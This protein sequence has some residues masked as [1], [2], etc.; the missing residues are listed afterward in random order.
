[1]IYAQPQGEN[2]IGELQFQ[3]KKASDAKWYR[4]LKIV[5]LSMTGMSVPQ[6]SQHFE[7]CKATIR[8]YIKAYNQGSIEALKPKKPTGRPPK[9]GQLTQDDWNQIL[10]Q[11]P[12]QYEKLQTDS[13]QWTMALLV[14]YAKEYMDQEVRLQTI[15]A[16]LK[17]CKFRTGRS[18]LRVGSPD[19]DYQVKRER[20]EQFRSLPPRGN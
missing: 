15:A 4:R 10:S 3:L 12:D 11:T 18:K 6:L 19:P 5:Q 1:M 17:R 13:R 16:A 8:S 7:V 2:A 14:R 9:V 20:V